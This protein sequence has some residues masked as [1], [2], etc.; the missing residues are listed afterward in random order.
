MLSNDRLPT[1]SE[2]DE[3]YSSPGATPAPW[4]DVSAELERAGVYWLSTVR[5][6][7]R[8]HVTPIA[9]V[10]MDGSVFF[11]TGPEER[12]A[13]NLARN[14]RTVITTGRNDFRSGLDVVVEGNALTVRDNATLERLVD[15]FTEKYEGHFG[16]TVR[17]GAFFHEQGGVA[18]VYEVAPVKVFAYGRG[19]EYSATRFRF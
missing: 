14:A 9:A 2:L 16:F 15:A 3:A 1:V 5:P 10:W 6:D 7:G 18:G 19:S 13:R 4:A 12:K 17:D 11:S 8:P